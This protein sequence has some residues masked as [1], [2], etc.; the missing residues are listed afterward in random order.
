LK[1][2]AS[3]GVFDWGTLTASEVGA[4]SSTHSHGNLTSEGRINTTVEGVP[5]I[6]GPNGAIQAGTS[7]TFA[8]GT[9]AHGSITSDGKMSGVTAR[10][11]LLTGSDGTINTL[12]V[13]TSNDGKLLRNNGSTSA[14]SW[15]AL[16][17]H[18]HGNITNAGAISGAAA[19]RVLVTGTGGAVT[20]LEASGT[21]NQVLVSKGA[22]AAPAWEALPASQSSVSNLSG[23]NTGSLPYQSAASTTT[24]LASA[25]VPNN[26]SQ[27]Q[28]RHSILRSGGSGQA[29]QWMT[30]GSI[31]T[32]NQGE[33]VATDATTGVAGSITR[34]TR[35]TAAAYAD[36]TKDPTTLYVVVG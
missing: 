17:S 21:L 22:N 30:A 36:A 14:P 9:H 12:S 33:Y 4:A 1:A 28:P 6:T 25:S 5:V 26:D 11:V 20:A 27:N 10:S 23:G 35:I 8:S 2:G 29:P 3:P 32:K 31:I 16:P 24:F 13:G 18:A 15:E 34:I 7:T 19:N